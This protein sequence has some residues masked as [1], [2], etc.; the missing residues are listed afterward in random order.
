MTNKKALC[1]V[2]WGPMSNRRL[3]TLEKGH[4]AI[5]NGFGHWCPAAV[6]TVTVSGP[7]GCGKTTLLK[8]LRETVAR[9][10]DQQIVAVLFEERRTEGQKMPRTILQTL[11][12]A[13]T[14]QTPGA[15]MEHLLRCAILQVI[16]E[17]AQLQ[18]DIA[19][20]ADNAYA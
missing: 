16:E 4:S 20:E 15:N 14:E 9:E 7:Q 13:I 12:D 10:W 17:H 2:E 11:A 18:R 8:L 6:M 1:G 5:R 19:E 3:C